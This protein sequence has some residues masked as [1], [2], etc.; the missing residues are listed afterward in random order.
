MRAARPLSAVCRRWT[1]QTATV[2]ITW[3]QV[4]QQQHPDLFLRLCAQ[5]DRALSAMGMAGV[6]AWVGRILDR[7]DTRGL[8]EAVA[9]IEGLDKFAADYHRRQSGAQ[10]AALAGF[11]EKY[12]IGLGGRPLRLLA[13]GRV[14][15]DTE[16]IYLPEALNVFACRED[17]AALY[18]LMA[19]YHWAQN[20][21][22]G[23]RVAATERLAQLPEPGR[24]L[25][26]D[27][28]GRAG[29]GRCVRC[30]HQEKIPGQSAVR[31]AF[32]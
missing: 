18:K 28:D 7:F 19:V 2:S 13:G 25:P 24:S 12:L 3:L 9:V 21:Y 22:G 23:W 20:Y 17:N 14:C 15:T 29:R 8:G 31:Q 11:L 10:L 32:F 27:R 5:L 26:V 4:M 6:D 30:A 16:A 1:R